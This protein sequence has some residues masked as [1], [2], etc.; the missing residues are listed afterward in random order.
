MNVFYTNVYPKAAADELCN[1]HLT[2]L[3]IEYAQLMSSCHRAVD[4]FGPLWLKHNGNDR[5]WW[6]HDS[7]TVN[8]KGKTVRL[9]G[10]VLLAGV[11]DEHSM[12][13]WIS[14]GRANYAWV[15]IAWERM[16]ENFKKVRGHPH[17][18]EKLYEVLFDFPEKLP[19]GGTP[20]LKQ[21][22][23]EFRH[24]QPPTEAYHAH[25][26][27]LLTLD[28]FRDAVFE[29]TTPTWLKKLPPKSYTQKIREN[30]TGVDEGPPK[31]TVKNL[32]VPKMKAPPLMK[33]TAPEIIKAANTAVALEKDKPAEDSKLKFIVNKGESDDS[34]RVDKQGGKQDL[35]GERTEKSKPPVFRI[36]TQR[37]KEK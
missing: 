3:L 18:Y 13:Q 27:H 36:P 14:A 15:F 23:P 21:V 19:E 32:G 20:H 37:Q 24:I 17:E 22:Y 6:L 4:G 7:D 5:K 12:L 16:L 29:V 28:K 34:R 8:Q 9:T 11:S 30:N 31:P 33:G 26:N 1:I 2:E 35:S 25:I 10:Y